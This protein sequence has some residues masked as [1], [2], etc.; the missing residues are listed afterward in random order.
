MQI[1]STKSSLHKEL[2]GELQLEEQFNSLEVTRN[3]YSQKIHQKG[4]DGGIQNNKIT[5]FNKNY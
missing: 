4:W 5:K 1:L 2:Q 3:K